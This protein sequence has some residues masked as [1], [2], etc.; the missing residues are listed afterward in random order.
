MWL[1]TD[2]INSKQCHFDVP[3]FSASLMKQWDHVFAKKK[4]GTSTAV[5]GF[6]RLPRLLH[7]PACARPSLL[8]ATNV[9]SLNMSS[10]AYH[11][12][13]LAFISMLRS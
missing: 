11:N 9:T 4:K 1:I 13:V 12:L 10:D 8:F 2:Q 5:F 7:K 3:R 6:V